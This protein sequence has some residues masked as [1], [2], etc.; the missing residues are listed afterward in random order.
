MEN[1]PLPTIAALDVFKDCGSCEDLAFSDRLKSIESEISSSES[2]YKHVAVAG[3]INAFPIHSDVGSVTKAELLKLYT[4]RMVPERS[5]GRTHY[6]KIRSAPEYNRC[7]LCGQRDVSTVDHYLPK[8]RYPKFSVVPCN[9]VPA[10]FECNKKKDATR[11]SDSAELTFH[12][13]F[14]NLGNDKWLTAEILTSPNPSIRFGVVPSQSWDSLTSQR[15]IHH[16]R[17]LKLND[18]YSSQASNELVSIAFANAK[19]FQSDG[20]AGLKSQLHVA[21]LSRSVRPNSWQSALYSGLVKSEWYCDGGF[22]HW[23]R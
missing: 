4:Q 5:P 7:P 2:L 9:L 6:D 20:A 8:A 3:L 23:S 1:L 19:V 18:L 21:A 14:D 22:K 13:Y 17:K 10:C 16:F 11:P 12:P 15:V